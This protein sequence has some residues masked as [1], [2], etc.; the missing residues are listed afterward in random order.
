MAKILVADDRQEARKMIGRR[1]RRDM[2]HTVTECKNAS[3][4]RAVLRKESFDLLLLD[5]RMP[6]VDGRPEIEDMGLQ[7]IK[8]VSKLNLDLDIIVITAYGTVSNA[9]EA[10]KLGAKD[11]LTKPIDNNELKLRVKHLLSHRELAEAY[12]TLVFENLVGKSEPMQQLFQRIR[13]VAATESTVLIRGE[14][15]TG[16]ELVAKAIHRLSPRRN[17]S[18]VIQGAPNLPKELVEAELFGSKRGAFTDGKTDRIGLIEAADQGTFFLDEIGDLPLELQAKFLRLLEEKEV[19]RIGENES[20]KVDVRFIAA[21]NHPLEEMVRHGKFRADLLDRLDIATLHIPPLRQRKEDIPLLVTHF[22]EDFNR[23]MGKHV[24]GIEPEA[25]D[26]MQQY[27]WPGNVRELRTV[28][29]RAF[30]F[31]DGARLTRKDVQL[32]AAKIEET[33]NGYIKLPLGTSMEKIKLEAF[34]QTYDFVNK[35]CVEASRLLGIAAST[36]FD[37]KSK[38][39]EDASEP[40]AI[41]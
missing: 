23:T 36:G 30:I 10:M 1:L 28:I 19:R 14:R 33:S 15:G 26:Y 31:L 37:Y 20:R 24:K 16:K 8:E 29:E 4:V 6:E 7:V 32:G 34:R 22:I 11:Y 27:S 39:K 5:M 3:E 25:L 40:S 13:Q 35:N 12:D 21:T 2:G 17:N 18:L 41:F 38:L 9:V